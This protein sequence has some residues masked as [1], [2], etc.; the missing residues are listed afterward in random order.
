MV[1]LTKQTLNNQKLNEIKGRAAGGREQQWCVALVVN[2]SIKAVQ[3][4]KRNHFFRAAIEIKPFGQLQS[5]NI[6]FS[7]PLASVEQKGRIQ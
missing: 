7:L 6:R 1:G 2:I 4:Y 3:I 5:G